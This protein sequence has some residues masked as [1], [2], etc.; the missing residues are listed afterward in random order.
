VFV[1][2]QNERYYDFLSENVPLGQAAL[3]YAEANKWDELTLKDVLDAAVGA[4]GKVQE[5]VQSVIGEAKDKSGSAA[6]SGE[7]VSAK[8]VGQAKATAQGAVQR[9]REAASGLKT[10]VEKSD[11]SSPVGM[12]KHQVEQ[13]TGEVAE[14][15]AKAEAALA[16]KALPST[17]EA[18]TT[19]EQPAGVPGETFPQTTATTEAVAAADAP[20]SYDT[21]LPL[22]FEP[23]PGY[24]RPKAKKAAPATSESAKTSEAAAAAALEPLPLIAP[25]VSELAASEPVIQQLASTIDQLASYLNANPSA[26]TNAKEVL[27]VAKGDL[28]ALSSRID[29]VREEERT[30]LESKLDEQTREYTV[31]LLEMEMEA[32]DKLDM[33]EEDFRKFF[34]AERAKLVQ[35]YREKLENELKTQTELINE[36]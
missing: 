35:A 25:A 5:V 15:V 29:K 21:P 32:Q 14:L 1:A 2:F 7:A 3:E 27:D 19:P 36:R 17:V 13:F 8:A 6:T 33:Q 26:A 24:S 23:P 4:A 11:G 34:E 16:G 9:V 12:A 30:Q 28:T 20:P 10:S 31:K 18:T 22:G